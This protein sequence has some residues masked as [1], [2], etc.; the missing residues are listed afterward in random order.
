MQRQNKP[1]TAQTALATTRIWL[2][3][4]LMICCITTTAQSL[5][6]ASYNIRYDSRKDSGNLWEDRKA[7]VADL[8]RF[9]DF[10]VVG[11]QEG[12]L[13]Q[14]QDL[15]DMLPSYS[16]S[17]SGRDD[18][19]T[20]GEHSAIFFRNDKFELLDHGDFW[21]AENPDVPQ[22]G[23]DAEC[24][25]R[26]VSWVKL[27]DKTNGRTFYFFSAHY[28]HQGQIARRESSKLILKKIPEITNGHTAILVGD[29]NAG[30]DSEPY[31]LLQTSGILV[32]AHSKTDDPYENNGSFNGFKTPKNS[33]V[34]DHIF[35]SPTI[36]V[37]KWGILTD[38]Y[39]GKYP[40]DHF[41]VMSV[42][43]FN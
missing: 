2:V 10:D 31:N 37:L 19:K 14:L 7:Y 39:F 12:L 34:I 3:A 21:L 30:R 1:T 20:A 41:P 27:Q 29:L 22:K 38:S 42:L 32:D 18:G 8:I 24:C 16:R 40:S 33:L 17:G 6:V 26:I 4:L 13:H 5:K 25:N 23:W 28:D 43:Q 9:H 15:D 11:T 35:I 36:D